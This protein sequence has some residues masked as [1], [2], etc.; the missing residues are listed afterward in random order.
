MARPA[1]D[2]DIGNGG[3][4]GSRPAATGIIAAAWTVTWLSGPLD[5]RINHQNGVSHVMRELLG[6]VPTQYSTGGRSRLL[7]ISKRGNSYLRR[8]MIHGARS[9]I[10]NVDRRAHAFGAW[11][12]Q[13]EQRVHG[14]VAAVSLANKLARIAWAVLRRAEPYRTATA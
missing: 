7:G 14:N 1:L 9:V 3:T 11:L 6:L 12:T 13:L 4:C 5:R 2:G 8:L 10:Q